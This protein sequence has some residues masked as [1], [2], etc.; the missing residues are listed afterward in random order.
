[1]PSNQYDY[2]NDDKD[3]DS[4]KKVIKEFDCPSCNANNPSEPLQDGSEVLCNYCGTEYKV[5]ISD[6]GKM[7]LKEM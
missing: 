7:K 2:D 1:M 5:T 3:N 6:E 4:G